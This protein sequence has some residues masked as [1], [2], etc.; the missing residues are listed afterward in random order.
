MSQPRDFRGMLYRLDNATK[1]ESIPALVQ[2]MMDETVLDGVLELKLIARTSDPASTNGSTQTSLPS[3]FISFRREGSE[4][5]AVALYGPR[6]SPRHPINSTSGRSSASRSSFVPSDFSLEVKKRYGPRTTLVWVFS[7]LVQRLITEG[8]STVIFEC[9]SYLAGSDVAREAR[10]ADAAA[11]AAAAAER[12]SKYLYPQ[13]TTTYHNQNVA[14]NPNVNQWQP[15]Q[16]QYQCAVPTQVTYGAPAYASSAWNGATYQLNNIPNVP[17]VPYNDQYVNQFGHATSEQQYHPLY[18]RTGHETFQ[19]S[20]NTHPQQRPQHPVSGSSTRVHR[21][22]PSPPRAEKDD[23]AVELLT[24]RAPF[25]RMIG[26]AGKKY[27]G[28]V[29]A[30]EVVDGVAATAFDDGFSGIG[31]AAIQAMGN[32]ISLASPYTSHGSRG[33]GSSHPF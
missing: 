15:Q 21:N 2:H 33:G 19:T 18:P 6:S 10:K 13:Q 32:G 4:V 14:Y 28:S 9:R 22:T 8:A 20:T 25:K 29:V 1:Y 27:D 7:P 12:E 26:Y 5:N 11:A 30:Y 17:N 24:R 23:D 31:M 16:Q 3:S